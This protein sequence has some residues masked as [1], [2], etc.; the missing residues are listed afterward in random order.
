MA[1][2]LPAGGFSP[3]SGLATLAC[4]AQVA[5]RNATLIKPVLTMLNFIVLAPVMVGTETIRPRNRFGGD[6]VVPRRKASR[7]KKM[8]QTSTHP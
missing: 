1:V 3:D 2:W 7:K 5:K 6:R 8:R 4:A